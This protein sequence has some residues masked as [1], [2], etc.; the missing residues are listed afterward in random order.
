MA[1]ATP[2]LTVADVTTML[3]AMLEQK[4]Y[5]NRA[6]PMLAFRFMLVGIVSRIVETILQK[7]I[8]SD[9]YG[10]NKQYKNQVVV[11][12]LNVLVSM[13][14]D[15]RTSHLMVGMKGVNADL[16][17]KWV[18]DMVTTDS[19]MFSLPIMGGR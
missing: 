14:A 13:M 11:F 10:P 4:L 6:D 8:P 16:L 2:G 5:T 12:V 15:K 3:T 18:T 17:A 1:D 19:V 9:I 7:N